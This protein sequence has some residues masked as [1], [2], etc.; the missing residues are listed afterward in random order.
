[1]EQRMHKST[2]TEDPISQ[3]IPV[4]GEDEELY[5]RKMHR[6]HTN[7]RPH[8]KDC[9]QTHNST[10]NKFNSRPLSGFTRGNYR[11]SQMFEDP[12]GFGTS[13]YYQRPL[14]GW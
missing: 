3:Q 4:T 14:F 5:P 7:N 2:R 13:P 11:Q 10:N 12:F 9:C 6:G 1:M 8:Q